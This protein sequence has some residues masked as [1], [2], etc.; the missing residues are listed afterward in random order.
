MLLAR[1]DCTSTELFWNKSSIWKMKNANLIKLIQSP[2]VI[3]FNGCVVFFDM[4]STLTCAHVLF[5]S[6]QNTF[7]MFKNSCD[8][9]FSSCR[10][11][12]KVS[13]VSKS[14]R[15]AVTSGKDVVGVVTTVDVLDVISPPV[16]AD[17]SLLSELL[18][19]VD[20]MRMRNQLMSFEFYSDFKCID[21][22]YT[23]TC[24]LACTYM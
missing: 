3:K 11:Q 2:Y 4:H 9:S 6:L 17:F 21:Y 19:S 20:G 12:L 8:V 23:C 16:S 5:T 14:P 24:T 22:M 15:D 7:C 10:V 1:Q 13:V 18:S